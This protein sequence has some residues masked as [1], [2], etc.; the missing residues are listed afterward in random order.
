[1]PP[2]STTNS[3]RKMLRLSRIVSGGQTGVD[4]AALD[5]AIEAGLPHGGWCPLG[6]LAEDGLIPPQYELA[7][8]ENADYR[9]RTECNVVDSDGTLIVYCRPL[10]GGTLLTA[11][12]AETHQR[13]CLLVDLNRRPVVAEIIGWLKEWGIETLNVAGPRESTQP[14]TYRRTRRLLTELLAAVPK[15]RKRP[16]RLKS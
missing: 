2:P 4:R 1:M 5:A 8:T 16:A 11:R 15:R 3:R 7:E 14:G 13:P 10:A 12:L 6:R 9:F